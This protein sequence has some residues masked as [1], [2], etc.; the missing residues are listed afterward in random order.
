[1][2]TGYRATLSFHLAP[3]RKPT[4][5][6]AIKHQQKTTNEPNPSHRL[7]A[8]NSS[9]RGQSRAIPPPDPA[10]AVQHLTGEEL[11]SITGWT[12]MRHRQLA[13]AG[14][15]PAP[16]RGRYKQRET[17]LGVI[18]YL[19]EQV[20]KSKAKG[21]K[22][23]LLKARREIAELT[24]SESR[25][26]LVE[27]VQVRRAWTNIAREQRQ[28]LIRKLETELIAKAPGKSPVELLVIVREIIDDVCVL[29]RAQGER[30]AEVDSS[31]EEP[32]ETK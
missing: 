21:E 23:L 28:L 6:F 18:R 3:F 4:L 16:V 5:G 9:D 17:L 31:I 20:R 22:E 8:K 29:T 12:D 10:P 11:C 24:L 15:F 30:W 14:Y 1:M 27:T 26:E 19:S 25:G 2:G 7:S 13:M 32:T